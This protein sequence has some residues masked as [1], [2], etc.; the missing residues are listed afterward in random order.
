VWNRGASATESLVAEGAAAAPSPRDAARGVEFVV[1]MLRDD[2][3]SRAVWLAPETGAFAGMEK[4]AVAI[5]SST[6]TVA[7]MRELGRRAQERG[8]AFLDAPVVGSRPQA[9]AGALIFL[10]GGDE[11]VLTLA[12]PVLRCMGAAIH[13]AGPSGHGA[14]LKLAVNA[15]FGIQVAAVAELIGLLRASGID[16]ARAGEI[17]GQ[18]PVCSPA[19]KGALASM[20]AGNFAPMF[21]VELVGK[22]FGY[23]RRFAEEHDAR[24]PVGDAASMVMAEAAARGMG[25]DNLTGIVRLY[26]P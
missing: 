16:C 26:A 24:T 6:L 12:A 22:D 13:H 3:A 9:D 23:I 11:E 7:C 18:A 14:A 25:A 5:D 1:A 21:P 20:L 10:V 2:E 19:A 15:L 17:I 4:D 8:I